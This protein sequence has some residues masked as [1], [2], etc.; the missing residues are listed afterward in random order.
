[1]GLASSLGLAGMGSSFG[2]GCSLGAGA[3]L[4][5][6]ISSSSS[7]NSPPAFAGE[8]EGEGEGEGAEEEAGAG[9]GEDDLACCEADPDASLG[10]PKTSS[11]EAMFLSLTLRLGGLL[12]MLLG[13]SLV[14][15][16][17]TLTSPSF[18]MYG[19][20]VGGKKKH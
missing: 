19:F 11:T 18:T 1:L 5:E 17:R 7:P 3:F 20:G 13:R 16:D 8:G 9:V 15:L 14:T 10:S 12:P 2:L 4:A 6:K